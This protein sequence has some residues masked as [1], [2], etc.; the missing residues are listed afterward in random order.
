MIDRLSLESGRTIFGADV[1]GYHRVRVDYPAALYAAIAARLGDAPLDSIAEI[2]PGTGIASVQLL[3][4]GPRRLVG[5]EPDLA[6]A[7]HLRHTVPAMEVVDC[8]FVAADVSGPFDL[9]AAAACFHWL[10]PQP[11]LA[12]IG[13]MVRPGGCVALWWNVY[14]EDGIG[15]D[16][17]QAVL[18]LLENVALPPSE[19]GV[20]HY[21]LDWKRHIAQLTDAGFVDPTFT[22]YRRARMLTPQM[23]SDLYASFSFIRAL[24]PGRRETLLASIADIVSDRFGGLAPSII[25]TPL[26]LAS[27]PYAVE[28]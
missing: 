12:K 23:A 22:I 14:R 11:A 25:V 16:F 18:P 1:A 4:L 9:V 17:A 21:S 10:D 8:D 15:D 20:G 5:F 26:Y 7:A 19:G 24:E 6:L 28:V 13:R 27:N 3:Q 2:G